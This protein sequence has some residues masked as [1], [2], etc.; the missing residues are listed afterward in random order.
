VVNGV[1]KSMP[2]E[3][4]ALRAVQPLGVPHAAGGMTWACFGLYVTGT[5]V[6]A[7]FGDSGEGEHAGR[8]G[9]PGAVVGGLCHGGALAG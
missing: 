2:F 9:V 4:D 8:G 6:A 5:R 3:F 1:K 7:G